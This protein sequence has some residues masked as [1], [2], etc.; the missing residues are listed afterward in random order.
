MKKLLKII[1]LV[2]FIFS[3]VGIASESTSGNNKMLKLLDL[4]NQ[5]ME[6]IK[7]IN[8]FERE[9][10]CNCEHRINEFFPTNSLL[11][12][13]L[14]IEL[15]GIKDFD[16]EG[17]K[18]NITSILIKLE[19]TIKKYKNNLSDEDSAVSFILE[20]EQI[21][22]DN[23]FWFDDYKPTIRDTFKIQSGFGFN[24]FTKSL[25]IL[26]I[27][28]LYNLPIKGIL[29][30]DHF[31]LQI[32]TNKGHIN[33]EITSKKNRMPSDDFYRTHFEVSPYLEKANIEM[34]PLSKEQILAE[35]YNNTYLHCKDLNTKQILINLAIKNSPKN[36]YFLGRRGTVFQD[37]GQFE[38]AINDY[39]LIIK[40]YPAMYLPYYSRAVNYKNV[41]QNKLAK[42]DLEYLIKNFKEQLS[43][44]DLI[45]VTEEI[46]KL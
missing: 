42:R 20:I 24:C 30:P 41:G 31:F 21:L 9:S 11:E 2:Y 17:I 14:K 38:K 16:I 23:N 13:A 12:S 10:D 25:L 22:E 33:W 45:E 29:V 46:K 40:M 15:I 5:S 26:H 27:T 36:P 28:E 32:Q 6:E 18:T 8:G 37:L 4:L 35:V 39:S 7:V 19:S 1:T 43:K 3:S 34:T 44:Q